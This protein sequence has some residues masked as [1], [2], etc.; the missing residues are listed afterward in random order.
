MT[1]LWIVHRDAR[2]RGALA[3]L[4]GAGAEPTLGSPTD[5]RFEAVA[6]PELVLLGLAGDLEIELEFAHRFASRLP[7]AAWFLVA[8]PVDVAEARRLFDALSAE[9][10]VYPPRPEELQRK[11][12]SALA[13]R[14]ADPLSERRVRDALAGSFARYFGDLEIPE[15]L[16]ALDPRLAGVPLLVRGEPGT[17]RRL[18]ARYVHAFGGTTGGAFAAIGCACVRTRAELDAEIERAAAHEGARSALTLCLEEVDRLPRLLQREVRDWV[19]IA[20]PAPAQRSPRLRI[21]ATAGEREEAELDPSLAD[22]LSG[23]VIRIPPLRARAASIPAFVADVTRSWARARGERPRQFSREALDVLAAMPWP[24]NHR[25]LEGVVTRSLAAGTADPIR[26]ED[27]RFEDA[28]GLGLAGPPPAA[29]ELG[30]EPEAG[31]VEVQGELEAGEASVPEADRRAEAARESVVPAPPRGS[32]P[33]PREPAPAPPPLEPAGRADPAL[34]RLL[35]ALAHE[36]RNPLVSIRTFADLLPERFE[37][38]EFRTRFAATVSGDV[39]RIERV[40]ARLSRLARAGAPETLAVD[41]A[42]LLEELVEERRAELQ[43]RELIVLKE[44]DR[45]R[46]FVRAD[47]TQLRDALEGVLDEALALVSDR[48]DLFVASKHHPAGLRGGPGVRVVVRFSDGAAAAGPVE[49]LSVAETSLDLVLA[50][51]LV[52]V[53]GGSFHLDTAAGRETVI[54]IDLPAVA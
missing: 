43:R 41:V 26:V 13:R 19:E 23:L 3:R 22:A 15:L 6:A 9:I 46:P 42:A 17:G 20:P 12:R 21:V 25:E 31:E 47:A 5:P 49:G 1:S 11:L 51:L 44:L 40:V 30:A 53:Q 24:G 45:S 32:A 35:G 36:V 16:R 39:A 7:G 14:S 37:D 34:R 48:G 52:R 29:I 38:E 8:E 50:E 18:L 54:V 33:A 10:L 27:L 2:V 4:T 28:G